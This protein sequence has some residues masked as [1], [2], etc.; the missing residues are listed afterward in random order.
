MPCSSS[1]LQPIPL[2]QLVVCTPR[3]GVE[4]QCTQP[5]A[6]SPTLCSLGRRNPA[7]CTDFC[8]VV[9]E[10]EL[11]GG[12]QPWGTSSSALASA[13]GGFTPSHHAGHASHRDTNAALRL[14]GSLLLCL[15]T[16]ILPFP[17]FCFEQQLTWALS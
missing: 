14:E 17:L 13:A 10:A 7:T 2:P 12:W 8:S 16:V 15:K 11:P 3:R 1:R 6:R 9:E 5:G 4:E